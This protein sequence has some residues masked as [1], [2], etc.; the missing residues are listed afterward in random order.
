MRLSHACLL[1]AVSLLS[2]PADLRAEPDEDGDVPAVGRPADLPFSGASGRFRVR[3]K[4]E[5]TAIEAETPLTFTLTVQG[6]GPV[7]RAP[8]R[9][10]L[11]QVQAFL[12]N[13]YI[14]DGEDRHPDETTWEFTYRLKPRRTDVREVPGVPFVSYDPALVGAGKPFQVAY[15]DPIRLRVREHAAVA[16]PLKA[17]PAALE[18]TTGPGVLARPLEWPIPGARL[19]VVFLLAPPAGCLV[20]WFVWRRLYPDTARRV[21][22]RRSRAARQALHALE[23][24]TGLSAETLAER[25]ASVMSGYLHE[26]LDLSPREPTPA[27]VK[28][29][30]LAHGQSPQLAEALGRFFEACDAVRFVPAGGPVP[31]LAAEAVNLILAAEA[32]PCP[33]LS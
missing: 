14:E 19:A 6:L 2:T 17:P 16:V 20:W 33:S 1:L 7:K 24:T 28:A 4:A 22:Q 26:R 9:L 8:H 10:D 23:H 25:A 29:H 18:I 15:T 13:F 31:D 32:V 5:P 21:Q 30:L 11:K 3:A 27:E 12:D